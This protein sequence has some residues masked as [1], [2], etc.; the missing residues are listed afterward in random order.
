MAAFIT[1]TFYLTMVAAGYVIELLFGVLHLIPSHR[2]AKALEA[3]VTWNYTTFLNIVFLL[4]AGI[5]LTRFVRS[6][7]LI[8]LKEMNR[9]PGSER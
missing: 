3:S 5:L 6:G 9:A 8:M 7:G 2:T 4:L 1:C